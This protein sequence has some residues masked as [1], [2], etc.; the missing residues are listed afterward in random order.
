[1]SPRIEVLGC[2]IDRL[3]LEETVE[4]CERLVDSRART[5]HISINAAKSVAVLRDA[6]LRKIVEAS[7]VVSADGQAVVWASRL[8]GNPLP[9]RVA[10]IDLM[11]RLLARAEEK[12]YR[13]Y[14]L[15]ARKE[16]LHS[17]VSRLRERFPTLQIVGYRDGYFGETESAAVCHEIRSAR[18]DILFVAMSSPRKEYWLAEHR[19]ELEVPLSMG[20]GGAVDVLAG[21]TRRAPGWMQQSGLEWLFRL[22]QEPG[23]LWRRYFFTNATFAALVVR[24]LARRRL[25]MSA[26]S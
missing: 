5:Q 1:M 14:V 8:L 22:L 11:E 26:R 9:E 12:G 6:K 2:S 3:D 25:R 18:P 17:A 23:R 24:E 21:I 7:D 16:V 13:I 19:H 20:V 10:G 15:G 4:Q